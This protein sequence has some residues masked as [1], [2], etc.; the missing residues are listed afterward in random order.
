MKVENLKIFKSAGL[1]ASSVALAATLASVPAVAYADEAVDNTK[2]ENI[3]D[4]N[5]TVENIVE[6]NVANGQSAPQEEKAEEALLQAQQAP[7]SDETKKV[8]EDAVVEEETNDTKEATEERQESEVHKVQTIT[9]KLDENGEHLAG[10]TLQIIDSEGNVV[11][12][13]VSDGTAHETM[14]P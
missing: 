5:L 2:I 13:W 4:E 11:D 12:E 3:S 1:L 10:A 14:L 9:V 7:E 8:E 6:E